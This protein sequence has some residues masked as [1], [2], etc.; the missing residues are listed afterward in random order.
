MIHDRDL[1]GC[2]TRHKA[3][4]FP[5]S[6]RVEARGT[7]TLASSRFLA[8][9]ALGDRQQGSSTVPSPG[10]GLFSREHQDGFTWNRYATYRS[11]LSRY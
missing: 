2:W 7:G 9:P 3:L 6:Q 10:Y 4:T 11:E 8:P 5:A 1:I